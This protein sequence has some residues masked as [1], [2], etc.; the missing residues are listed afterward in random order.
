MGR[1]SVWVALVLGISQSHAYDKIETYGDSLTA[2]FMSSTDV[3]NAP[4]LVEMSGIVSDLAMFF[5]TK[6][7][8]YLRDHHAPELAWP[9]LLAKKLGGNTPLPLENQAVS[10]ARAWSL[11]NQVRARPAGNAPSRA[12]FFIG[13]ND[14]CNN[15]DTPQ[16]VADVF[17]GEV[18][19]ALEEWNK[20]HSGS[21]AYIVPVGQIA[22]VYK[23]LN[24]Y[25]WRKGGSKDYSCVD[26]WTKLFPYCVSH[27][28]KHKA[29]TLD[30]YLKPRRDGMN[31]VLGELAQEWTQRATGNRFE[32]LEDAHAMQYVPEFFAVDCFHLSPRGQQTVADRVEELLEQ[33]E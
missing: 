28:Q 11:V 22:E 8:A 14:L 18:N 29:G 30:A 10:G 7:V 2:G 4:P 24:G 32:Y 17:K 19:A 27:F 21:I 9:S 13:H 26:S 23:V 20:T 25:V 6:D 33:V 31:R 12:F 5:V 1:L 16:T 15:N 3:T